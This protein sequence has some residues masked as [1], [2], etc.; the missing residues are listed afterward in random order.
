MIIP[1]EEENPVTELVET[2]NRGDVNGPGG[3]ENVPSS[4]ENQPNKT[5]QINIQLID[6]GANDLA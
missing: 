4:E 1:N 2:A 5:P 3:E 6:Q